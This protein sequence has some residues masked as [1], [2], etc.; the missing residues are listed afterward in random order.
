MN[1][2]PWNVPLPPDFSLSG[3][4][5]F[6]QAAPTLSYPWVITGGG[7]KDPSLGIIGPREADQEGI[8]LQTIY[9]DGSSQCLP[10]NEFPQPPVLVQMDWDWIEFH[11]SPFLDVDVEG[12]HWVPDPRVFCSRQRIRNRSSQHRDISLNLIFQ[13]ETGRSGFRFSSQTH[14]GR[15]ILS[16]SSPNQHLAVF[17]TEGEHDPRG[18][19]N[20]LRSRVGLSPGGCLDIRWILAIGDSWAESI[21]FLEEII[22]LDWEGEISRRLIYQAGGLQ[23]RTGI[24]EW[25]FSLAF[26]QR[27]ARLILNQLLPPRVGGGLSVPPLNPFQAWTLYQALPVLDPE[28]MERIVQAACGDENG[29]DPPFPLQAEL[30]WQAFRSGASRDL[31]TSAIPVVERNLQ[32]WFS[33]AYDIDGDGV[34]E[35]PGWFSTQFSLF[36]PGG[37]SW[38]HS[39]GFLETPGLAALLDNA[40]NRLKDLQEQLSGETPSEILSAKMGKLR[41]YLAGSWQESLSRYQSRDAISHLSE[42][43]YRLQERIS[44]GWNMLKID[45]PY[46]SRLILRI[47]GRRSGRPSIDLR[48]T[49]QGYDWRGRYRIEELTTRDIQWSL[50]GGWGITSCTFAR[51]DTCSLQSPAE[52]LEIVISAPPSDRKDLRITLPLWLD[53]P[54]P[55]QGSELIDAWLAEV[56]P[57]WSN[58]GLKTTPLPGRQPVQLPLNSLSAQGLLRNGRQALAGKLFTHWMKAAEI[59]ISRIGCLFSAW[60]ANTGIGSGKGNQLEGLLPARLLLEAAGV[61]IGKPSELVIDGV[62]PPFFPVELAYRGA[63]IRIEE[64]ETI[65]RAASGETRIIPRGDKTILR[66]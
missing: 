43:G 36:P 20:R 8:D 14:Q 21:N 12:V 50:K 60:D 5:R 4:K 66:L 58:F 26:S 55:H 37:D 24:P 10:P 18:P 47:F 54:D 40:I 57:F 23:I 53:G 49:L 3:K 46:P 11:C 29:G 27:T 17:M 13:G 31:I 39:D 45:L 19:S 56:T 15:L 65:M 59:N 2:S 1:Q 7:Q 35:E 38:T 62:S 51:L 33:K 34:P 63:V 30:L 48:V 42:E 64:A 44:A 22:A 9:C 52:D 6:P 32:R 61:R 41:A 28:E 16:G 25:D